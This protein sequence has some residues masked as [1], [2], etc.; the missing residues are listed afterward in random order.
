M[1]SFK[2]FCLL[3]ILSY[4]ISIISFI[5]TFGNLGANLNSTDSLWMIFKCYLGYFAISSFS[6]VYI[7]EKLENKS[8]NIIRNLLA[9]S[10]CLFVLLLVFNLFLLKIWFPLNENLYSKT[11]SNYFFCLCIFLFEYLVITLLTYSSKAYKLVFDEK[12]LFY[13]KL[14]FSISTV[15]SIF[16]MILILNQIQSALPS[17]DYLTENRLLYIFLEIAVHCLIVTSISLAFIWGLSRFSWFK[18]NN[19]LI[20]LILFL[21]QIFLLKLQIRVYGNHYLNSFFDSSILSVPLLMIVLLYHN[22]QRNTDFKLKSLTS[23]VS[24][25]EAEYLQLKNQVNPHFLFNNLNTL[26]SFIEINP[27]K[28]VEFGH[29]LSNTYRHYLKNQNDDFVLL[30][31]ELEFIKEYLAIYKA[32]FEHGF[33]F[34]ISALPKENEYILSL[35]LQEIVDNIFKHNSMDEHSPLKIQIYTAES[36]LLIENSVSNKISEQSNQVGLENINKRYTILTNK[37]IQIFS[38]SSVYQVNL[39]ILT[40]ES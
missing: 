25:K 17:F 33:S 36:G 12:K 19:L 23:A 34:K 30:K 39:P 10:L 21:T 26:I 29:H 7:F 35:S 2:K 8:K 18:Q 11:A 13:I 40:L 14:I 31:E 9:T 3:T 32:K 6:Y 27:K 22:N 15:V 28:A 16:G 24:K 5:A 1:K 37:E 4:S 20:V 38:S